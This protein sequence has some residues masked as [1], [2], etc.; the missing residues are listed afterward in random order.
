MNVLES[1][2]CGS[3]IAEDSDY[4]CSR[5]CSLQDS[6]NSLMGDPPPPP[7]RP[8]SPVTELHLPGMEKF[9][10]WKSHYRRLIAYRAAYDAQEAEAL[11]QIDSL[12]DIRYKQRPQ[13]DFAFKSEDP[14]A[15]L[16]SPPGLQVLNVTP[17]HSVSFGNPSLGL[18]M[19]FFAPPSPA[20]TEDSSSESRKGS[21]CEDLDYQH[22]F[23]APSPLAFDGACHPA[24]SKPRKRLRKVYNLVLAAT[25]MMRNATAGRT[26]RN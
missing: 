8:L 15:R 25:V 18:S 20:T 22:A 2:F 10:S 4:F 12:V 19:S 1:C 5:E 7:S 21:D 16:L 6:L 9:P 24:A 3:P 17:T 23:D 11:S 26:L 13:A 14:E